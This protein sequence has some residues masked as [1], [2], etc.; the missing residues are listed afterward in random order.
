M[1]SIDI[2]RFPCN[3]FLFTAIFWC[4][5]YFRP[6]KFS[7][8]FKKLF[9]SSIS[10]FCLV[11]WTYVPRGKHRIWMSRIKVIFS[12][13]HIIENVIDN[14]GKKYIIHFVGLCVVLD[15]I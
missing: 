5:I 3:F 9:T 4:V 7:Q 13:S 8:N 2:Y 15:S 11:N 12:N 10:K 1:Y 6:R 14:T